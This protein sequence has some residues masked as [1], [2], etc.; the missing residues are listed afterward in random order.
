MCTYQWLFNKNNSY[1][2]KKKLRQFLVQQK[3]NSP[4]LKILNSSKIYHRI[5]SRLAEKLEPHYWCFRQILNKLKSIVCSEVRWLCKPDLNRNILG[6]ATNGKP[7]LAVHL[8][9]NPFFSQSFLVTTISCI[10]RYNAQSMIFSLYLLLEE[11][12]R[13]ERA[14]GLIS[15]L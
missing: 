15:F 11:Y 4:H 2:L 9:A 8:E 12:K 10:Y 7:P 1:T 13:T 14:T 3:L 5:N 6:C